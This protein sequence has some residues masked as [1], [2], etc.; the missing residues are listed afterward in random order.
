MTSLLCLASRGF[1]IDLDA[2]LRI[3]RRVNFRSFRYAVANDK[4][5]KAGHVLIEAHQYAPV[6]LIQPHPQR[7][8]VSLV[9]LLRSLCDWAQWRWQTS[10][11]HRCP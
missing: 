8:I 7:P 11:Q 6:P 4:V 1:V 9:R 2:R 10:S 5:T 3:E